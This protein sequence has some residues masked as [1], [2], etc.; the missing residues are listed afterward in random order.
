MWES[1]IR[2]LNIDWKFGLA[3]EQLR[4]CQSSS[5]MSN[6]AHMQAHQRFCWLSL[7]WQNSPVLAVSECKDGL[8][9]GFWVSQRE[10]EFVAYWVLMVSSD[11]AQSGSQ[12][13]YSWGVQLSMKL[14]M[15]MVQLAFTNISWLLT[16]YQ[17]YIF[18]ISYFV[19]IIITSCQQAFFFYY[20]T[21]PNRSIW[22]A[23]AL[24]CPSSGRGLWFLYAQVGFK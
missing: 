10:C 7:A 9:A 6:S 21:G 12:I 11:S 15:Y 14:S 3:P 16:N 19:G 8:R 23:D 4:L 24:V 17:L 1:T 13:I 5:V 18:L 20:T 22:V 2:L